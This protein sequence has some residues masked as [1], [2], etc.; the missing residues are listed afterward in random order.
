M[1]RGVEERQDI[2]SGRHPAPSTESADRALHTHDLVTS[3]TKDDLVVVDETM[4]C[5]G[6]Y[7]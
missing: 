6:G 7:S 5:C 2:A 3:G 1:Q 4:I